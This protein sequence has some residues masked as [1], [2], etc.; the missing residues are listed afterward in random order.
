AYKKVTYDVE[1]M[2]KVWA[3]TI[4]FKAP[5][6]VGKVYPEIKPGKYTYKDKTKFPFDKMMWKLMY[7]RF[8]P[9]PASGK[10]HACNFT[11]IE[12]VPTRQYY[13][14]LPVAEATKKYMGTVREDKNGYI[15]NES[16][17]AGFPFPRP[18]GAHQAQQIIYNWDK[19]YNLDG[20]FYWEHVFGYT[21]DLRNDY[22]GMATAYTMRAQGRIKWAPLGWLD[23]RAREQGETRASQYMS[24]APRDLFGN[25]ISMTSYI[26][27]TK[28]DLFLMYIN[29]IRRIRKLT[30]S[31]TQDPA[32]GQ[33]IIYE[34]WQGFNQKLS[35]KRYPYKYELIGEGEFLVPI[36]T[37]GAP[38]MSSKEG[39][40]LKNLQFERRPCWVVQLTQ[41]DKNYVYGK[42]IFYVDKE[43][44]YPHHIESYDQ[45]GR[46]YRTYDAVW[47]FIPEMGT[48]NQFHTLA[49][50]HID[51]HS[52]AYHSYSYPALWLNRSDVSMSGMIKNK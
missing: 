49:L 19:S 25:I 43:I 52:T 10:R 28:D 29:S 30:A 41:L 39:F 44:L 37:D 31:D 42:R 24:Q 8:N 34:D 47:G 14:S 22:E 50:D 20:E 2:K 38:Y 27:P 51:T 35:P 46:L 11:E 36:T 18:S 15:I 13:H 9:T 7:D 23:S 1:T 12:I 26:D 3:E 6:V 16:Y 33:D 5:N 32:V 40:I 17:V 48:Y 4:G 45:K 21:G